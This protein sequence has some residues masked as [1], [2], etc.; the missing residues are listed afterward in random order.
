M[1]I[2]IRGEQKFDWA[3]QPTPI[4]AEIDGLD[5]W[6]DWVGL[7]KLKFSIIGSGCRFY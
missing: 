6:L 2:Q 4:Q 7:L 1:I 5:F 3:D